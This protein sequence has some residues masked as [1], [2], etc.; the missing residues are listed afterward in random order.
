MMLSLSAR[1]DIA[2]E[3]FLRMYAN[4]V[5]LKPAHSRGSR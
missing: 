5:A 2:M 1:Q 4:S 3:R